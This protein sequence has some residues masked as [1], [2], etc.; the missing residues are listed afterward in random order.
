M[1]KNTATL[2]INQTDIV[3][4]CINFVNTRMNLQ[5]LEYI[6]A[7][8]TYRHFVTAAEKCYVTQATLSTMVKKLESELGVKLFDRSKHP[9]VPT[10]IGKKIIEQAKVIVRETAR[11]KEMLEEETI[12]V[13]GELKI[14]IIPTLA[15]YLIPLFLQGFLKNYPKI[16]LQISELTTHEIVQRIKQNQ[17]DAGILAIPLNDTDLIEAPLFNEEFIVYTSNETTYPASK[18][19]LPKDIDINRLWLLDEGHCLRNQVINLCE[20]KLHERNIHQFDLSAASIETLKKVVDL[21]E[22]ITVLPYLALFDL[23]PKQKNQIRY[24]KSP[25]PMRQI[26]LVCFRYFVKEKMLQALKTEILHNIPAAMK[27]N[28]LNV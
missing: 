12:K 23:T 26:G 3:Y 13:N 10:V 24:F 17:L 9:V 7:V 4:I 14:G 25:A 8:D 15:P 19:I 18:Y 6:I 27:D 21:N 16:K 22:G 11:V 28:V 1:N 2:V 5:Q 20:L